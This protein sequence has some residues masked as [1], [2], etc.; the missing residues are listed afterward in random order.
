MALAFAHATGT[1]LKRDD[2]TRSAEGVNLSIRGGES[3][4]CEGA[5]V[6]GD[7]SCDRVVA[8]VNCDG[9]GGTLRVGVLSDHLGESEALGQVW[10][11][12]RAY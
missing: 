10:G 8:G 12:W 4:T 11:N 7:S 5:V 9:I 1:R 3:T 6:C 2:V